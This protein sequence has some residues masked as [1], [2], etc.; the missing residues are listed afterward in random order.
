MKIL[1]LQ[2]PLLD[3]GLNYIDGNHQYAPALLS[4]Y[5]KNRFPDI[6]TEYLHSQIINIFSD[7]MLI[8]YVNNLKPDIVSFSTYLWNAERS[9]FIA[10]KI[11]F[12]NSKQGGIIIFKKNNESGILNSVFIIFILLLSE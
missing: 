11:I 7:N 1:F 10:E 5:I 9:L 4:C 2:L 3:H 12:R 6:Q 8:R